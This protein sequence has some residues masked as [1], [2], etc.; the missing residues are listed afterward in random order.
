MKKLNM[1]LILKDLFNPLQMRMWK[2]GFEKT[3]CGSPFTATGKTKIGTLPEK[4]RET[5]ELFEENLNSK[6]EVYFNDV[7]YFLADENNVLI[8]QGFIDENNLAFTLEQDFESH[9]YFILFAAAL[10]LENQKL[11]DTILNDET[12]LTHLVKCMYAGQV[13]AAH[14]NH[15]QK[16]AR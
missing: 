8:Y 12:H 2:S 16:S 4:C 14:Y 11:I 9:P 13:L 5:M 1:Q 6:V 7:H 15:D 10:V 3:G